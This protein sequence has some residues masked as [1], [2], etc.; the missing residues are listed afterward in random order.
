MQGS[1]VHDIKAL[2][3]ESKPGSH[4]HILYYSEIKYGEIKNSQRRLFRKI[5][6][7]GSKSSMWL[8]IELLHYELIF[9]KKGVP[10]LE[11]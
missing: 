5:S 8:F 1:T 3:P 4:H 10:K 2:I 6:D 9:L 11:Y 7:W